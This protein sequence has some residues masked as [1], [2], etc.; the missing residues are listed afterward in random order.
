MKH[1]DRNTLITAFALTAFAVTAHAVPIERRDYVIGNPA[2]LP[3]SI[4]V[5]FIRAAKGPDYTA[6]DAMRSYIVDSRDI[7]RA[8]AWGWRI[9]GEFILCLQIEEPEAVSAVFSDL[10]KL[11]PKTP[12]NDVGP[13]IISLGKQATR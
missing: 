11:I 1:P 3:C 2:D 4:R 12:A 9:D 8:E 10:S 7:Q 6:W 13:T 5:E